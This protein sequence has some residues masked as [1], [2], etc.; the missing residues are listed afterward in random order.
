MYSSPPIHGAA[1]VVGVLSDPQLYGLWR[2]EL[3][4]MAGRIQDMRTA[5]KQALLEVRC[6]GNWDHITNQI[7]MFSYTGLSKAQ[8]EHMTRKWHV[9]MTMDGRISMA[10]LSGARA[11]YLA[12][13]IKDSVANC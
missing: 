13:A 5:L 12:E 2:Q 7:G 11:R 6:P 8:C 10:G 3:A 4:A 9:Y 1:I